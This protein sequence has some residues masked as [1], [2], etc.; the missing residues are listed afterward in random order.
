MITR[1]QLRGD[2]LA[3]WLSAD[4]ILMEREM[5]LVSTDVSAPNIYDGKKIGDGV[6]KFSEL[7]M[8]EFGSEKFVDLLKTHIDNDTIYWDETNHVIKA[9]GGGVVPPSDTVEINVAVNPTDALKVTVTGVGHTD[10]VESTDKTSFIFKVK[11]GTSFTVNLTPKSGYEVMRVNVDRVSQGAINSYTF[12][13]VTEAH[14]MY[15]WM[16]TSAS[17]NPVDWLERSDKLGTFYSSYQSA[18][19]ALKEDYPE[20][21][22]ADVT[23]STVK[24]ALYIRTGAYFMAELAQF[25]KDSNFVLTIDG[26]NR[27]TLNCASLGGLR[28]DHVDNVVVKNIKFINHSNYIDA[29]SPDEMSAIN[30]AG[31]V[32]SVSTNIYVENCNIDGVH[33]TNKNARASFAVIG[34]YVN[35]VYLLNNVIRN[36]NVMAIKMQDCP[37][38]SVIKNDIVCDMNDGYAGHPMLCLHSNGRATFVEDNILTGDSSENYFLL[39]NIDRVTFSRNKIMN[40]RGRVAEIVSKLPV[41]EITIDGNLLVNMLGSPRYGWIHEYFAFGDTNKLTVTNNTVYMGTTYYMQRFLYS[42]QGTVQNV[43]LF[44]NLIL[45][46]PISNDG[47]S[48]NAV[49]IKKVINYE[50][51]GNIYQFPLRADG[52]TASAGV[53]FFQKEDGSG[54]QG[55]HKLSEMIAAGYE[56]SDSLLVGTAVNLLEIN[57][58][59]NSYAITQ[60]YNNDYKGRSEYAGIDVEYK[61]KADINNSR[62]CYNLAGTPIDEETD[63]TVGYTGNDLSEDRSFTNAATYSTY[64]ESLLLL[65]HNTRNRNKLIKLKAVGEQHSELVLGK[66]ALLRLLPNVNDSGEYLFDENY[67]INIE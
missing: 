36:V 58:G 1:I 8:I 39:T 12:N 56:S 2:T 13:N 64:A 23:L 44:N 25:N 41:K 6:H 43:K 49:G 30:I 54:T 31:D 47:K 9:K 66:Y 29:G 45:A 37:L 53:I 34:K 32:D 18:F 38:L 21:L 26:A 27:T 15:I 40:G 20:K 19:D 22:T 16:Q 11:T 7:P 5:V 14:T 4:P 62:G 63:V 61:A 51:G 24:D 57:N 55:Y 67:T 60:Q 59:G 52:I 48:F 65:M 50:A 46:K 35:N 17:V 10:V 28:F 42:D 33:S 3:N